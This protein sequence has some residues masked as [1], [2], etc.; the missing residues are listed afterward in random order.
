MNLKDI[1]EYQK[2]IDGKIYFDYS[3]KN[4]NW[5][6]IGGKSK[7]FFKPANLKELVN[8][9]K[10]YNNRGK[11][12]VLGA[13]SNVLIS[14]NIFDGVIIKL[15]QRFNNISLLKE[16]TVIA[17]ANVLDKKLSEFCKEFEIGGLEFLSCIPGTVGGGI[18][19][20]SGCYNKDFK[21]FIISVQG[22]DFNGNVHTI[23]S[24]K[25][26]FSY[27][28]T[29]LS[30]KL[31]FLSATFQGKKKEKN[32]INAEINRLMNIKKSSQPSKI[33]TSGSTFKNPK[34][35]NGLKVWELIKNSVPDQVQ[36][37]DAY[38]SNNHSNFFVNKN[39]ASFQD[40]Y[41]LINFVKMKVKKKYNINLELEVVVV[42]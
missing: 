29:N 7:I 33:K 25:I 14:D 20:N 16:N 35:S 4:L 28:D 23:P 38:I 30:K 13:G 12:F 21:D 34:N 8:F 19:M 39:N 17:G 32:K 15:G 42:K 36:F 24:N 22:I 31:I 2:N 27:R 10:I 40:M 37:G 18:R 41:K 5:F 11:I 1:I 3:I 9:L 26:K 6:N